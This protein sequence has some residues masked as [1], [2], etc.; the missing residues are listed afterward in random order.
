[1]PKK[2]LIGVWMLLI[3][4]TFFLSGTMPWLF[5]VWPENVIWSTLKMVSLVSLLIFKP[6]ALM[7]KNSF[8]KVLSCCSCEVPQIII[9]SLI[10]FA[11]LIPV[12]TNSICFWKLSN[13][14][15]I[16]YM[17]RL[18]WYTP[19]CVAKAVI[20]WLSSSKRIDGNLLLN[21]IY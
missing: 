11:F 15:L 6:F 10:F 2:C 20:G 8:S 18:Y 7:R 1:M 16:L 17:S 19:S 4:S 13:A 21:L 5:N 14:Q 9:S 12:M 3:V